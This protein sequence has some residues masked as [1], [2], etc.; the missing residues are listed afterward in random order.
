MTEHLEPRF[1]RRSKAETRAVP[2]RQDAVPPKPGRAARAGFGARAGQ[3][4]EVLTRS[5]RLL[6]VRCGADLEAAGALAVARLPLVGHLAIDAR[7]WGADD[8]ARFAAGAVLRAWRF[9]R[10]LTRP[11]PD[12]PVL[13]RLDVLVDD[14]EAAR[15]AWAALH[16]GVS[17]ALFARDLVVEPGNVLTP[18]AFIERLRVLEQH[19]IGVEVMDVAQLRAEGFG[20]LL[21]VG[22]G[23]ANP[24][25]L[26]VLRWPGTLR[27]APVMF[28]GKGITFDTGGVCIKP[29]QDMWAM[30][31]D[32]AG[33][34]ACAGAMLA[35]ALRGSASPAVA[36]LPLA[37][38]MTGATSYRPGDVLHLYSGTTVEVVDTDAEGRLVLADALAWGVATQR[39]QAVI[40]LAT[41]TGSIITA[42]G[43]DRAGLFATSDVLAGHLASAGA[44]VDERTWRM[45]LS[46]A[47]GE[48]LESD[49]AD[50]RHCVD[51]RMQPD[52]C[53]A[54]QF[55]R[56]FVGDV[57]WVHLDIAGV[58]S[59]ETAS[60]RAAAGPTGWGVRLLDR[61][62]QERFED[63]ARQSAPDPE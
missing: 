58:E 32:M 35:L 46:A 18:A 38:N 41:L 13:R 8:A 17:G 24:P 42:L 54:A 15:R 40:D 16:P 14:P 12:R 34:A 10:L 52:A 33:A 30:R 60:D 19:G 61:L 62:V 22:G 63:P 6:L 47:Y 51:G 21:A 20:G 1:R 59:H 26:V 50:I 43:H 28:V 36:V 45:P 48:A 27:A 44:A 31:A 49:I 25:C 56:G 55:L 11:D 57:P 4:A 23:S 39:P 53:H 29:A 37:E 9:D 3:V 7:G 2:V 5:H